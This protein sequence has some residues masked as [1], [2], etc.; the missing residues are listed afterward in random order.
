MFVFFF[1]I[2]FSIRYRYIPVPSFCLSRLN[3]IRRY[4]GR[5]SYFTMLGGR[6]RCLQAPSLLCVS[7]NM[8][9][10]P[11]CILKQNPRRICRHRCKRTRIRAYAIVPHFFLLVFFL[12]LLFVNTSTQTCILA[13]WVPRFRLFR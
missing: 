12:L 2:F 1:W 7:M 8:A 9:D 3:I 6:H 11:P 4:D 5:D 13:I 10:G